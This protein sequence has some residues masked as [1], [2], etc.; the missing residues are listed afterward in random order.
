MTLAKGWIPP[1]RCEG[2]L[3]GL[4]GP[5]QHLRQRVDDQL[6]CTWDAKNSW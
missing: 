3:I 5:Q 6:P 4:H 1:G 2:D